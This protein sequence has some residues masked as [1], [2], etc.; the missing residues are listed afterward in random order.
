MKICPRPLQRAAG[1]LFYGH[2][3][4]RIAKIAGSSNGRTSTFGVE[5]RGPNPWPAK[6]LIHASCACANDEYISKL[7]SVRMGVDSANG[8]FAPWGVATGPWQRWV[9]R[10]VD[11]F[12]HTLNLLPAT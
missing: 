2:F 8:E 9:R 4:R 1:T 5:Y 10:N 11:V 12:L 3:S 6:N 7:T